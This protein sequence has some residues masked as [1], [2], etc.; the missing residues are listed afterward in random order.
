MLFPLP[1]LFASVPFAFAQGTHY[2][3][4]PTWG[5]RDYRAKGYITSMET[6]LTAGP[7]PAK[8]AP[9][10]ALWPGMDTTKGLV[11]PIIV[12][13]SEGLY[14][15]A[16][17][18]GATKE[19]WCVFASM[20][21]GN[22]KQEM[23]KRVPLSGDEKLVMKFQYNETLGGYEQWLYIKDKMVSTLSIA[24]GKSNSFYV[25]T[26]CQGSH[27][28]SVSAHNYTDT[29]IVLSEANPSW[30]LKPNNHY[31]ACADKSSS[32]DGGKTWKIPNIWLQKSEA[33]KDY[34][35]PQTPGPSFC[36]EGPKARE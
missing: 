24:S 30:G 33:M 21:V 26:E 20:V 12:S 15:G 11:Q 16:Q 34:Q 10:M 3:Y 14:Q 29:T 19:Q 27:K 8:V 28:G 32:E 7:V 4:G 25:D 22:R 35:R 18:G 36:P 23:G 9:R 6:T 31:L 1:L 5:F 17:C 13:S 2:L